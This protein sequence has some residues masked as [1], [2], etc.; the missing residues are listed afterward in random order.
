[1]SISIPLEG[2]PMFLEA[3]AQPLGHL[4][5]GNIPSWQIADF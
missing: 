4:V 2:S 1:M 3:Q 5:N